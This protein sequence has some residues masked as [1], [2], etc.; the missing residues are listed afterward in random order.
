[1][2]SVMG[3]EWSDIAGAAQPVCFPVE[4]DVR[5]ECRY[6]HFVHDL[7]AAVLSSAE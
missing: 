5:Q 7:A 2:Q 6:V 3:C 1:M 4:R